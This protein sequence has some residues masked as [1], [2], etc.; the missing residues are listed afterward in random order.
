MRPIWQTQG[1]LIENSF[2]MF[3]FSE[4]L[5]CPAVLAPVSQVWSYQ[6]I[7]L[8]DE[9][10]R[11]VSDKKKLPCGVLAHVGDTTFLCRPV[12]R[13]ARGHN[14]VTVSPAVSV[15]EGLSTEYASG[16]VKLATHLEKSGAA[17]S[18]GRKLE[19]MEPLFSDLDVA[20]HISVTVVTSKVGTAVRSEELLVALQSVLLVQGAVVHLRD[21]DVGNLL[22]VDALLIESASGV[23]ESKVI[24]VKRGSTQVKISR[25]ICLERLRSLS[26]YEPRRLG[27]IRRQRAALVTALRRRRTVGL[28]GVLLSGPP[29]GGK[30]SLL[31]EVAYGEGFLVREAHCADLLRSEGGGTSEEVRRVFQECKRHQEEGG[32][33]LVLDNIGEEITAVSKYLQVGNGFFFAEILCPQRES[34]KIHELQTTSTLFSCLDDL[35][36]SASGIVVVGITTKIQEVPLLEENPT[37]NQ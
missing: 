31:E 20:E 32:V 13:A 12:I 30:S 36:R 1:V 15:I 6:R 26:R 24:F 23:V 28:R 14:F 17:S 11:K 34:P 27:G 22:G 8:S 25:K 9:K 10:L 29:G 3:S 18:S 7:L 21:T 2:S 16:F 37:C 35:Q 33:L 4:M 19:R 5:P